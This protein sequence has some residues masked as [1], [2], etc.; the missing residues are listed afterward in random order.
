[1]SVKHWKVLN[2]KRIRHNV[3]LDM[4][5]LPNGNT[6]EAMVLEFR[7]W[8]C[9]IALTPDQKVVLIR[10]DRHGAGDVVW[11]IP[12]GVVDAEDENLEAAA[13]RELMEE[14]GFAADKW[15]HLASLSPDPCSHNNKINSFLAL[16]AHKVSDQDLDENEDIEV[17]LIPLDE[18]VKMARNSELPQS[19]QVSALFLA[20]AHLGRV[21]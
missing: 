16:D 1:M 4:C 2:T 7:P 3:R 8:V 17:H 14:S 5:E 6:L 12:G 13:K 20:L 21:A 18:V 19:M 9:V 11:E 15:V 10:Q